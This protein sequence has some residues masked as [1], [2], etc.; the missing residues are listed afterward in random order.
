VVAKTDIIVIG[1]GL[2]GLQAANTLLEAGKCVQ[3]LE[4]RSRVGG[5]TL[6]VSSDDP[7]IQEPG[8]N[9]LGDAP[10]SPIDLGGQWVGPDQHRIHKLLK[11]L[12]LDT[13]ATHHA[14]SKRLDDRGDVT[15]YKGSIPRVSPLALLELHGALSHLDR[16]RKKLDVD[17]PWEHQQAAFFDGI[18][19]EAWKRRSIANPAVR[20]LIDTVARVVLGVEPAEISLLYFLFY[21]QSG[22]GLLKLTDVEGGAQER[23]LVTGAQQISERLAGKLGRGGVALDTPVHRITYG[24]GGVQVDTP[25]QAYTARAC[26]VAIPPALTAALTFTPP[27]PP[28]RAQL[29]QRMPQGSLI[30]CIITY[31]SAWWRA[32]DQSGEL[33]STDGP[34]CFVCD[35]SD[36]GLQTPALVAFLGGDAARAHGE[37][38]VT[39][40]RQ[41][42]EAELVRCFGPEAGQ[43]TGYLEKNWAADPW[44]RGCP[45]GVMGPGNFRRFGPVLRTPVGNLFWA[46]T[47]TASEWCGYMEGA[48]QSGERAASE[49]LS[50]LG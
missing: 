47:E 25:K 3:V 8:F 5:R 42:V 10:K 40:R 23:R 27:L 31:R 1:A 39:A 17:A 22:G 46:G 50:H 44:A 18:S 21:I 7:N 13:F 4:A 14:G 35:N 43:T 45:V 9:I 6:T 2:A 48:L 36:P 30:K 29:L 33:V 37:M 38:S 41:Q 20:G 49:A 34:L 32:Q 28:N 26:I 12:N 19:L 11:D 24:S 15:S 16:L